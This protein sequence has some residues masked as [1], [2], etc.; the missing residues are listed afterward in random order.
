MTFL[1]IF[2]THPF[3]I[4]FFCQF[5][6]QQLLLWIASHPWQPTMPV[7]SGRSSQT[8]L[9]G[10]LA[11]PLVPVWRLRCALSFS[12][13]INQWSVCFYSMDHIHL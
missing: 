13:R 1:Y 8:D 10:S 12:H 6:L 5:F 4:Y 9:I 3:F 11:I 7:V 2:P